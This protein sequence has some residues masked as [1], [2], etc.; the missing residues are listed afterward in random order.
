MPSVQILPLQIPSSIHPAPLPYVPPSTSSNV[1]LQQIVP[2]SNAQVVPSG[3]FA[4]IVG[5]TSFSALPDGVGYDRRMLLSKRYFSGPVPPVGKDEDIQYEMN[6]SEKVE[7]PLPAPPMGT[8]P[9]TLLD[10][11][12]WKPYQI[13]ELNTYAKRK[14]FVE[15]LLDSAL[16]VPEDQLQNVCK[17]LVQ[18]VSKHSPMFPMDTKTLQIFALALIANDLQISSIVEDA[19]SWQIDG[20]NIWLFRPKG[21]PG[22][23]FANTPTNSTSYYHWYH[24][25]GLE[26]VFGTLATGTILP[27]C[28]DGLQLPSMIPLPGFF[29]RVRREDSQITQEQLLQDCRDMHSY[30]KECSWYSFFWSHSGQS[31]QVASSIYLVGAV[32]MFQSRFG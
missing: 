24:A 27:C 23:T 10:P 28:S 6:E 12:L 11:S 22:P 3:A 9:L 4:P 15:P 21:M 7:I 29:A 8:L 14:T 26:T 32:Y 19:A 13:N 30:G 31:Y 5:T 2:A 16:R 25:G 1:G 20:V 18:L 17:Q